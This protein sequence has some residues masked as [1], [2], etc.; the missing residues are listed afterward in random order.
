MKLLKLLIVGVLVSLF[1]V[2]AQAGD[3]IGTVA[4]MD[5][6]I[7]RARLGPASPGTGT[8]NV[9]YETDSNLLSWEISWSG[10]L[11]SPTLMHFHGPASP[12]ENGD[13]QV[14]LG[15]AGLPVT[16]NTV[17]SE[18]QE[19]DLLAGLWYVDLHTTEYPDGEIRGNLV[20]QTVDTQSSSFGSLLALYR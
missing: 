3:V 6:E 2:P 7:V 18:N 5:G 4:D 16:G 8:A 15:V 10:L 14:S 11:G 20:E 12:S 17:L 13:V 9:L 1:S 19:A